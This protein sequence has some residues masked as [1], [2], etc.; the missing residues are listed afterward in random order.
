MYNFQDIKV[1][2]LWLNVAETPSE[3]SILH[4]LN[5]TIAKWAIKSMSDK[6]K[7]NKGF[8]ATLGEVTC[9]PRW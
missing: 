5:S 3:P 6:K 7:I 8:R 4:T 1:R 2:E 9:N